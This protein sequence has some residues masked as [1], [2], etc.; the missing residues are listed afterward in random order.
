MLATSAALLALIVMWFHF[1]PPRTF[2][3]RR[4]VVFAVLAQ[5]V[6]ALL[7]LLTGGAASEYL[8]YV[9]LLVVTTVYSPRARHTLLVAAA[10]AV[11]LVVVGVA[12]TR[13]HSPELVVARV[14]NGLLVLIAFALLTTLVGNALREA[15]RSEAL[16]A[17][18]LARSQQEAQQL[19]LTDKLTGLFNRH[20]GDATLERL[21]AEAR[22]GRPFSVLTLDLDGLKKINDRYGHAAGD[23]ALTEVARVL[24][25]T[26]RASDV[27][28]RSGG[29]EFIA[30]LPDTDVVTAGRIGDRVRA[31]LER[32]RLTNG[33]L[34]VGASM[35]VAQWTPGAA[36]D[37][38]LREADAALY[39]AKRR[40]KGAA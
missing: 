36:A 9:N 7:L 25:S 1:V 32:G 40:R 31:A 23:A 16:R 2:G 34:A 29:D 27:P 22:R 5:P 20:H 30:L 10:S 26:L 33:D 37:D 8:P 15:R 24:R 38:V 39:A 3:D 21:V 17:A 6:I 14:G 13:E 28:I 4:V 18:E 35:G 19:A 12:A 11:T